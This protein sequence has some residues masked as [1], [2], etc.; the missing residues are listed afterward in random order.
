MKECHIIFNNAIHLLFFYFTRNVQGT[1][2]VQTRPLQLRGERF[3]FRGE[4]PNN[5]TPKRDPMVT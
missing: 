3:H 1:K 2:M 5:Q 4:T